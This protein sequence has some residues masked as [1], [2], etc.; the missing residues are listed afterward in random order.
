MQ[1]SRA[2]RLPN[3]VSAA[4]LFAYLINSSVHDF[5]TQLSRAI[6]LRSRGD[7]LALVPWADFLNHR[8]DCTAHLDWQDGCVVLTADKQYAPGQ[9]IC[10]LK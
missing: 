9:Q 4:H 5:N 7:R 2:I 10:E 3:Q 1:L 8:P 6:R